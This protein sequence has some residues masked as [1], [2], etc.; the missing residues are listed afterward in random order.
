M[1][2]TNPI[3][4]GDIHMT[5]KTFNT[6]KGTSISYLDKGEGRAVV[7]IHGFVGNFHY[8]DQVIES[9]SKNYRVIAIDL[10]VHGQSSVSSEIS[11][12]EDYADEVASLIQHLHLAKIS[13]IGHSLG[14]YIT[15]AFARKYPALLERFAL[16]HST[17]LADTEEAKAGRLAGMEKIRSEGLQSFV[18]ELIPKLFAP[19]QLP[20][21]EQ[22]A[23]N[24]GYQTSIEGA[25]TA[26]RVM[27]SRPDLSAVLATAR[28]PVL[29]VAGQEDKVV[30]PQRAFV[31]T[32]NHMKQVVIPSVGHMSMYEAPGRLIR[33]LQD[34]LV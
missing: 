13:L 10:P 16:I 9:L 6:N 21:Y 18:D 33:E 20:K 30:P 5:T 4:L 27:R 7:L 31:I 32:G 17:A 8:W 34:F 23:K 11:S 1:M 29:I 3:L 2:G 28:V 25:L 26:L 22:I 19:N 14:G 24:I 15:M 12:T